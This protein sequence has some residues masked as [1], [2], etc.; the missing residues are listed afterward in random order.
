[1]AYVILGHPEDSDC[2][3]IYSR[4]KHLNEVNSLLY[5]KL[6]ATDSG[7]VWVTVGHALQH[8]ASITKCG[9]DELHTALD[10]LALVER[11]CQP[12]LIWYFLPS[13]CEDNELLGAVLRASLCLNSRIIL[14]SSGAG[15]KDKVESLWISDYISLVMLAD[16]QSLTLPHWRGHLLLPVALSGAVMELVSEVNLSTV[17]SCMLGHTYSLQLGIPGTHQLLQHSGYVVRMV[18]SQKGSAASSLPSAASARLSQSAQVREITSTEQWISYVLRENLQKPELRPFGPVHYKYFLI[19]AHDS[20]AAFLCSEFDTDELTSLLL[21]IGSESHIEQSLASL[22]HTL[23]D[24]S[25]SPQSLSQELRLT[26]TMLESL[27][28]R[29]Q[30]PWEC[31]AREVQDTPLWAEREALKCYTQAHPELQQSDPSQ[32]D[33]KENSGSALTLDS[34]KS[35]FSMDGIALDPKYRL[36][37]GNFEKS[38]L[39]EHAWPHARLH[40][41][42]GICY[43]TE[44][45]MSNTVDP[46][47]L[48]YRDKCGFSETASLY[49]SNLLYSKQKVAVPTSSVKQRSSRVSRHMSSA[50]SSKATA[51][52]LGSPSKK[53]LRVLPSKASGK[54]TTSQPVIPKKTSLKEGATCSR[55]E[56]ASR[57]KRNE[58]KMKQA[59]SKAL[60][61]KGVRHGDKHYD[62]YEKE[63]FTLSM[64]SVKELKTSFDLEKKMRD[65]AD[66]YAPAAV[67]TVNMKSK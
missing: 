23:K 8:S 4:L 62:E 43:H 66:A 6:K 55:E 57:N 1:M 50:N 41:G 64:R 42:P 67:M 53:L 28:K 10:A 2:E 22:Y 52:R 33:S 7:A 16:I 46:R 38:G 59:V 63:L 20:N 3:D 51:K 54:S 26:H 14:I 29:S 44:D 56:K 40:Y 45:D 47:L 30:H 11:K 35:H 49:S 9:T 36:R 5:T 13:H 39:R 60:A 25:L 24:P 15:S 61:K 37:S 58:M 31:M 12:T 32:I 65:I 18:A 17:H 48:M 27:L 34:V 21:F 19:H